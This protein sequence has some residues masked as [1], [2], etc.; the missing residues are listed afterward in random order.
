[1]NSNPNSKKMKCNLPAKSKG[2]PPLLDRVS[3]F[4]LNLVTCPRN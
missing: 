3:N 4:G 1:M 2:D